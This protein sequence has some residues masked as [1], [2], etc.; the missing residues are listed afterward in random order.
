MPDLGWTK[1]NDEQEAQQ[2]LQGIFE[3]NQHILTLKSDL[4]FFFEDKEAQLYDKLTELSVQC[5]QELDKHG[6]FYRDDEEIP[7]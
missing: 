5:N 4:L 3:M 2:Y 6:W 7:Y 1:F